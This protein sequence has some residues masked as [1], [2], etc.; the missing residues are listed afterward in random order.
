[1]WLCV[2]LAESIVGL[3]VRHVAMDPAETVLEAAH[4]SIVSRLFAIVAFI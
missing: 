3:Q 2:Q 1:M 4:L